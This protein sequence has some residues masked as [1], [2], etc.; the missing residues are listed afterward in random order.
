[1][2]RQS[3]GTIVSVA[4]ECVCLVKNGLGRVAAR[5]VTPLLGWQGCASRKVESR[6]QSVGWQDDVQ[7][8][9]GAH[10]R[11]DSRKEDR[12]DCG[13]PRSAESATF[14]IDNRPIGTGGDELIDATSSG[15]T[16]IGPIR[17]RHV[18]QCELNCS[19]LNINRSSWKLVW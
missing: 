14:Y 16:G 10:T 12:R 7:A 18:V 5:W 8:R 9:I 19:I 4:L 1:M 13:E 3:K 11:Q 17:F 2:V 15:A 6:G